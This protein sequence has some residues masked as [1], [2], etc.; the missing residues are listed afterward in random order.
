[1]MISLPGEPCYIFA[2]L[3][4]MVSYFILTLYYYRFVETPTPILS[5]I[6][7]VTP[8]HELNELVSDYKWL[9]YFSWCSVNASIHMFRVTLFKW[10]VSQWA[11]KWY[12][13]LLYFVVSIFIAVANSSI[14]AFV[15]L[16]V[17]L[18]VRPDVHLS[19]RPSACPFVHPFARPSVCPLYL[20][21]GVTS[22]S[23][24][25]FFCLS[26]QT[27]VCSDIHPYIHLLVCLSVC[28]SACPSILPSVRPS[29]CLSVHLSVH[30]SLCPSIPLSVCLSVCPSIPRVCPSLCLSVCPCLSICQSVDL[31]FCLSV[32]NNIPYL[33]L[34][35]EL[36]GFYCE[37][38]GWYKPLYNGITLCAVLF[39]L[40]CLF[41]SVGGEGSW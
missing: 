17:C 11:T 16:S 30:P 5:P 28:P 4:K 31:S 10:S 29:L 34:I 6:T 18:S 36:C 41:V 40:P 8:Q 2:S 13:W 19:V 37:Y 23:I 38:F 12:M 25:A 20:F 33:D 1:M 21:I 3:L 15:G 14:I 35:R 24:V 27:S 7:S 39:L 32:V 22:S 9:V 26:I